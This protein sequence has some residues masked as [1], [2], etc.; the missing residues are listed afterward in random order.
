M[1]RSAWQR[2]WCAKVNAEN[3][4]DAVAFL[5]TALPDFW[6]RGHGQ[7]TH[8]EWGVVN[9]LHVG[10]DTTY[11]CLN[12]SAEPRESDRVNMRDVGTNHIGFVVDDIQGVVDRLAAAGHKGSPV[13]QDDPFRKNAYFSYDTESQFEFVEYLSDVPAERNTY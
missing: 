3:I 11:V 13:M 12:A 8:K 5:T 10:D 1:T 6:I 2:P 9:W 7:F 4:D